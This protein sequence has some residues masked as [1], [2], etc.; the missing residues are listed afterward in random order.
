MTL[1]VPNIGNGDIEAE[2]DHQGVIYTSPTTNP[3][4]HVV[5]FS[6]G[7]GS[8]AAARRVVDRYGASTTVL[9]CADTRSEHDDWRAFVDAAAADLGAELVMLDYGLDVW[10]LAAKQRMIPNTRADFCS[11]ILKRELLD[12]WRDKWCDPEI[13]TIHFGFDWTEGH[14]LDRITERLAPWRCDAPL[15]W[16]PP[17]DKQQIL[18]QLATSQLPF[19]TAYTLGLPHNNCLKYGCVK[20]GQA[21]WRR[22][23][24]ELP[25][26]YARS[27]AAEE[28]MRAEIGD[29]AILRDRT[30]GTTTPVSLRTFRQRIEQQPRL[31]DPTDWGSCACMEPAEDHN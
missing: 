5:Q 6:G 26:A 21:Y 24:E 15:C 14:R 29:H 22:I 30:G 10:E 9:L 20:G 4:E 28:A 18:D 19:P 3:I 12:A 31:F 1:A 11:R 8:W 16:D 7:A 13:C 17:L 2:V 23:L 27:E 25:E